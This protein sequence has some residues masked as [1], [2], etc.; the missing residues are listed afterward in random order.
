MKYLEEKPGENLC[1]NGLGNHFLNRKAKA[2]TMKEKIN[3]AFIKIE[4]L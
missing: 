2:Q 4:N 3:N 1:D